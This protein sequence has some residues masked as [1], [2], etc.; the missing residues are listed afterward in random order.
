V[1]GGM[2]KFQSVAPTHKTLHLE[3]PRLARQDLVIGPAQDVKGVRS[4]PVSGR[5]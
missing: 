2:P 4:M 1:T 5:E 3:T